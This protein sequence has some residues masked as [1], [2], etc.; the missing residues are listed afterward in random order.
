MTLFTVVLGLFDSLVSP[1]LCSAL[2]R[3][4]LH[5]LRLFVHITLRTEIRLIPY[6]V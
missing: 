6:P 2:S 4:K 5:S 3:F 1:L